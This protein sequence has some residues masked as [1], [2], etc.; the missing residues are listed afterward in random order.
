MYIPVRN[1]KDPV[2]GLTF[3]IGRQYTFLITFGNTGGGTGE[4]GEAI[5]F[6]VNVQPWDDVEVPL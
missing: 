3:E 2:V 5:I 6:D 4:L 1:P